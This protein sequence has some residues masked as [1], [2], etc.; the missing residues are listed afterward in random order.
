MEGFRSTFSEY[1]DLIRGRVKSI[2]QSI[3]QIATVSLECAGIFRP[4]TIAVTYGLF[5]PQSNGKPP[6]PPQAIGALLELTR[7][8]MQQQASFDVSL[9]Y[10]TDLRITELQFRGGR[11]LRWTK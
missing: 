4:T 5:A 3:N 8:Q 7:E 10:N 9:C 6:L 2:H 1:F 11:S